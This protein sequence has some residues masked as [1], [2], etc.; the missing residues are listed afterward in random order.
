[1]PPYRPAFRDP[2]SYTLQHNSFTT[3]HSL[4]KVQASAPGPEGPAASGPLL[5]HRWPSDSPSLALIF[6]EISARLFHCFCFAWCYWKAWCFN[7]SLS[8]FFW[9]LGVLP[10]CLSLAELDSS[11]GI[12]LRVYTLFGPVFPGTLLIC[13]FGLLLFKSIILNYI[14]KY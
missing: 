9:W 1:M 11:T 10:G 2:S 13:R 8:L 4:N 5:P 7:L 3:T 14:F 6:F 12:C